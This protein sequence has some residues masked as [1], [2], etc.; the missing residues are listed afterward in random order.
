MKNRSVKS[1]PI[2]FSAI[3]LTLMACSKT[4]DQK[5]P[6]DPVP[7]NLSADQ[8]SLVR[9][10]NTF[11]FDLFKKVLENADESKNIII[12]PLSIS[13]ALSMTLNGASGE[14]LNGML[15]ALRV[16]GLTP[17][18]INSSY[19]DLSSALLS[20]D[21]KVL[22]S[23]ANSIWLEK[24][25][26]VKVPFR[27]VLTE[28]YSAEA[29]SFDISDPLAYK[30]INSWIEDKTNGLIKEMLDGI[31]DQTQLMLI[32][33]IYFKGKWSI[34]FDKKNTADNSFYT[35]NGTTIQVPMMKQVDDFKVFQGDGF[36]LAELPY[37]QGNFVMDVLMPT[38]GNGLSSL[39]PILSDDSFNSLL[40]QIT[41][42]KTDL[43]F[44]RFKYGYKSPLKDI[45][46]S[47]GME[48][49]FS[50]FA[51]FSNISDMNLKI[52]DVLHQAFIETNEDGTEAAA[53]TVVEIVNTV[54]VET[55]LL[56]FDHPFIYIIRET[57]TN[58]ILFMGKVADPLAG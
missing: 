37:G 45:L 27:D 5:L 56:R 18:N 19:R 20:V 30:A 43:M 38:D 58:S 29:Q 13:Y 23:I 33:A 46:T 12:S 9:S 1:A 4:S 28:Y 40:E 42:R 41:R 2:L 51:D 16:S 8:L 21:K 52:K 39:T 25:F 50:D 32:N 14:T 17:E 26:E 11:A 3:F 24:N 55:L 35:M 34:Q 10:E 6:S 54:A 47:M 49:A 53:A 31:P 57:T 7:I 44:P 22:I 36:V 15:E 48:I